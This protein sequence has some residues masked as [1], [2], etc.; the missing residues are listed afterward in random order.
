[1]LNVSEIS[2]FV[3]CP[4]KLYL[5]YS[6]D[7]EAK[8]GEMIAGKAIHDARRGFEEILQHNTWNLTSDMEI[9]QIQ[10]VILEGVPEYLDELHSKYLIYYKSYKE[11]LNRV[12]RELKEDLIIEASINVLKIKKLMKSTQKDGREIS[13]ILFPQSL[14]EFPLENKELNLK[15]KVD[16]IEIINHVYYPVVIKTGFP[17]SRGVWLSD[18]LQ[19]AAYSLLMDYELNKEVLVGFV[20]YTKIFE[21]RTVVI[22]SNLHNKLFDVLNSINV[23]FEREEIPEFRRNKNKC[24]KCEY[25]EICGPLDIHTF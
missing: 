20:Y 22:N 8:S 6:E 24:R 25:L 23:M 10:R 19:I 17:P 9:A 2:I 7:I 11:N 3:Y 12:F 5:K 4:L 16:K 1:M 13:Q 21:R 15:G 14:V 18:S